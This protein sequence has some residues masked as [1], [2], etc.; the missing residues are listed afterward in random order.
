[1]TK[2]VLD[3]VAN[4]ESQTAA[5]Q[6]LNANFAKIEAAIENTVSRD[7]DTPNAMLAP[8]DMNSFQII[9]LPIPTVASEAVRKD[10]VD[11]LVGT[12]NEERLDEAIAAYPLTVQFRN[13][14]ETFRNEA[15]VFRDQAAS[16]VGAA[17]S[18][19]KWS[20]ARTITVG[21]DL[22]GTSSA[23]DGS[24]DLAGFNLT[25]V[26]DAVTNAK[27]ANVPTATVK[28]RSA[29]GSGDPSDLDMPTLSHMLGLT[30]QVALFATSAVPFGWLKC[31]GAAVSRTTYANLF[32]V[33]GTTF[34]AGDGTTTFNVPDLRGE[35]IRVWDDGKGTDS[36]RTFGSFQNHALQNHTHGFPGGASLFPAGI[37]G[38]FSGTSG[39]QFN[40]PFSQTANSG[41]TGTFASETRPRNIAL[42]AYI[43]Y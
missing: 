42:A 39:F 12:L 11:N 3:D 26:N 31:D 34:G 28:G 25:I 29:A 19:Q 5:V 4:L 7:G 36:G 6:T 33:I 2:L 37:G 30:G 8:L 22:S 23:W 21:G 13:Q 27:L 35:F 24:T 9:N 32:S 20:T 18:A 17:V 40:S 14:A 16:F 15:Q 38:G 43:R 1:M 10:Y 41:T